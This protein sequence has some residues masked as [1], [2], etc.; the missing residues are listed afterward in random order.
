MKHAYL[1]ILVLASLSFPAIAQEAKPQDMKCNTSSDCVITLPENGMPEC[2]SV[3][4]QAA[5][6]TPWPEGKPTPQ[7]ALKCGCMKQ[8]GAC[9]YAPPS[10]LK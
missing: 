8:I 4:S 2:S 3:K 10:Y 5:K 1:S 9:A 6:E 7:S